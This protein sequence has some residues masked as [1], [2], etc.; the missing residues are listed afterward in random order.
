MKRRR[1]FLDNTF[2]KIDNYSRPSYMRFLIISL[3]LTILLYLFYWIIYAN[4]DLF[5]NN[6]IK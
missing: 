1:N 4:I 2:S 5:C 6:W 3:Y